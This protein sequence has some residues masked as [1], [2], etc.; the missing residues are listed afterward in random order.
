[1]SGPVV[2][3][4]RH[5]PAG[6]LPAPVCALVV[7]DRDGSIDTA[8]RASN[9]AVQSLATVTAALEYI[10]TQ[11]PTDVA[12][13]DVAGRDDGALALVIAL[14]RHRY[15][16]SVPIVLLARKLDS[17]YLDRAFDAGADDCLTHPAGASLTARVRQLAAL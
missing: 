10:A 13:I 4:R 16:H 7:G 2:Q 15:W 14:R 12:V 17:T 6:T 8:L 5:L 9:I 3:F 11:L 1:V